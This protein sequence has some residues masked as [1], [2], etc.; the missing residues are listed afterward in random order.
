MLSQSMTMLLAH[1][2]LDSP[3]LTHYD[4]LAEFSDRFLDVLLNS[5]RVI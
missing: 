4:V 1:A 2:Q 3:K 5:F